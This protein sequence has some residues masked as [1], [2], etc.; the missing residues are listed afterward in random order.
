MPPSHE[1]ATVCCRSRVPWSVPQHLPQQQAADFFATRAPI[2]YA[3][4]DPRSAGQGAAPVPS[5]C[6]TYNLCCLCLRGQ[7]MPVSA[8]SVVHKEPSGDCLCLDFCARCSLQHKMIQAIVRSGR[9]L[10][11]QASEP[12]AS[13]PLSVFVPPTTRVA[14]KPSAGDFCFFL[15]AV[16]ISSGT[17]QRVFLI[18]LC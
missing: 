15:I 13:E 8:S 4:P 17:Y 10:N 7:S 11:T 16:G 14:P 2:A 18:F 12:Q 6:N 3:V 9:N 5:Y 1:V